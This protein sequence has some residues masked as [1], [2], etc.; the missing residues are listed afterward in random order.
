MDVIA[1]QPGIGL[2]HPSGF[3]QH[4][5]QLLAFLHGQCQRFLRVDV[6]PGQAGIDVHLSVPMVGRTDVHHVDVVAF[7]HF[8]IIF[9]QGRFAPVALDRLFTDVTVHIADGDHVAVWQGVIGIHGSLVPHADGP[10]PEAIVFGF[11]DI[12]RGRVSG[13]HVGDQRATAG[14]RRLQ[15]LSTIHFHGMPPKSKGFDLPSPRGR[16]I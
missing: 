3:P 7:Q 4:G 5:H 16:G 9:V 10:D 11:G 15:Q 2:H 14:S 6:L 8:A 12:R 13:E 1:A